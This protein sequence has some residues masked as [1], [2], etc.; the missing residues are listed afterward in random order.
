MVHRRARELVSRSN[1]THTIAIGPTISRGLI[2]QLIYIIEA[3]SQH[4]WHLQTPN[5]ALSILVSYVVRRH[6]TPLL[7]EKGTTLQIMHEREPSPPLF[8]HVDQD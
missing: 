6:T 4:L 7:K 8:L 3:V 2:L 1:D 5:F